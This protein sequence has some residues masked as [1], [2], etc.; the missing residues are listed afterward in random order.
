MQLF[1]QWRHVTLSWEIPHPCHVSGNEKCRYKSHFRLRVHPH[2]SWM[3]TD[4]E[5]NYFYIVFLL[6]IPSRCVY[7]INSR[8]TW[9]L[10]LRDFVTGLTALGRTSRRF[11]RKGGCLL[12]LRCPIQCFGLVIDLKE[13]VEGLPWNRPWHGVRIFAICA[14]ISDN[15]YN[16]LTPYSVLHSTNIF[17]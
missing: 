14:S 13:N 5:G 11:K 12:I 15:Y 10:C 2:K 7:W 16:Y 17:K 3:S 9:F 6:A 8:N 1:S 4:C